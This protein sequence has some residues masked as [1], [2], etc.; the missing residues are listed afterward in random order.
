MEI[1]IKRKRVREIPTIIILSLMEII[2]AGVIFLAPGIIGKIFCLMCMLGTLLVIF[3]SVEELLKE[4]KISE[5][6]IFIK[7][8]RN[9]SSNRII[10]CEYASKQ[11]VYGNKRSDIVTLRYD[12]KHYFD[13]DSYN[14]TNYDAIL[15][16]IVRNNIEV[17][18]AHQREYSKI[19]KSIQNRLKNS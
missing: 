18:T 11:R 15:E 8:G 16:Y 2:M 6:N 9:I 14:C 1:V 3:L 12:E 5:N 17:K 7:Y 4:V 19:K 13:I 10:I